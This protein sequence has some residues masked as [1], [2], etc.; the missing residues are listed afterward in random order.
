MYELP[1]LKFNYDALE[2]HLDAETLKIHYSKHHAAYVKKF[3]DAIEGTKLEDKSPIDLIKN[4]DSVPENLRVAIRNN[5]GGAHN[6]SF[7]WEILC[8]EEMSGEPGEKTSSAINKAFG[9]FDEFKKQF[10]EAATTVFGS[11][12]AWL[13][14]GTNGLE[15]IKTANQ[16]NPVVQGKKP[17]LT[18]D[19]WEHAYYLKYRNLRLDYIA[20]FFNVINWK[21]VEENLV[22]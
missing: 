10:S 12:W 7:F 6:H 9:N 1:E 17:I 13:V 18:L 11:G 5:G 19:V 16:D 4:L 8:P 21:K 20:A 14:V 2:P 15:I 3:N 22:G